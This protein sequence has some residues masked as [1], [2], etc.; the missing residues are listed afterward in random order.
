MFAV[1]VQEC[2]SAARPPQ[3][4]HGNSYDRHID[5]GTG[6]STL[7]E[8]LIDTITAAPGPHAGF[9][10]VT[11]IST[12]SPQSCHSHSLIMAAMPST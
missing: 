1:D 9:D 2:L 12:S 10:D 7:R 8:R 3:H 11:I 6:G 5:P 4:P